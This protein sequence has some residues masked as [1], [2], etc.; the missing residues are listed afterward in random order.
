M[1]K[2]GQGLVYRVIILTL[3]IDATPGMQDGCVVLPKRLTNG[4][5]GEVRELTGKEHGDLPRKGN[6]RRAFLAHH[7]GKT[8][9]VIFG[10]R[11]LNTLDGKHFL[12]FGIQRVVQEFFQA[13]KRD[14]TFG[15]TGK[16]GG[17][18]QGALKASYV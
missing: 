6:I 5:E 7:V 3:L 12:F 15:Q 18:N 9:I 1:F 13:F 10:N 8:D 16:G 2:Q 17:A 4:W 14:F 11:T